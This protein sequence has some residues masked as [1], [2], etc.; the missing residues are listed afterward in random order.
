MLMDGIQ[1]I[2]IGDWGYQSEPLTIY[3]ERGICAYLA[4]LFLSLITIVKIRHVRAFDGTPYSRPSI[5]VS[6]PNNRASITECRQLRTLSS[7]QCCELA[8]VPSAVSP[9]N[10]GNSEPLIWIIRYRDS[11]S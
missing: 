8:H 5:V 7:R 6:P 1:V 4:C 9:Y 3:A 10:H 2:R 11:A